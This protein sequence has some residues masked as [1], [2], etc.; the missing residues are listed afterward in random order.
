[1]AKLSISTAWDETSAFIGRE[2]RL[3]LPLALAFLFLPPLIVSLSIP[4]VNPTDLSHSGLTLTVLL[5]QLLISGAGQ[6]AIARLA[7]GHRERLGETLGHAARRVLPYV[8]S[9]LLIAVPL[10]FVLLTAGTMSK[11]LV[12]KGN[13]TV[14]I[15]VSLLTILFF[16]LLLVAIVRCTLNIA[17]AAVEPGGPIQIVKRGFALTKGQVWRLMGAV[18]LVLIGGG[19]AVYAVS[20]IVGSVVTLLLGKPEPWTVSALLIA[21]AGTAVQAAL[22]TV[23][24]VLCARIYAQRVT[25]TGVPSSGT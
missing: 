25:E 15:V 12:A 7:L 17:I 2:T 6:I 22:I 14:G 10:S 19:I 23:F 8:A 9:I 3:L 4:Q 20:I 24:S 1:M 11:V 5:V 16:V 18:A 13:T 21:V